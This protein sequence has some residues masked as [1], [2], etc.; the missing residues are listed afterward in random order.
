[1]SDEERLR[2]E[3]AIQSRR[4]EIAE[5][6]W[7]FINDCVGVQQAESDLRKAL[8]QVLDRL[9]AEDYAAVAL[10]GYKEV[11]SGFAFAAGD[12]QHADER[13]I[14]FAIDPSI[15]VSREKP[16]QPSVLTLLNRDAIRMFFHSVCPERSSSLAPFSSASPS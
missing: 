16:V 5:V 15:Q 7:D 13:T 14:G 9:D 12:G 8:D 10:L 3:T 2:V 11:A 1:M 6:D 4:E